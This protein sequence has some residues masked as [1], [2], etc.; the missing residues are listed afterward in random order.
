MRAHGVQDFPDPKEDG[1]FSIP[2]SAVADP[3]FVAARQACD[4]FG[5]LNKPGNNT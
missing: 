1:S 4:Q 5:K 3:Q 2:G